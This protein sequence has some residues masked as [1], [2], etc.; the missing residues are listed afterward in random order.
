MGFQIA[1]EPT[2][3]FYVFADASAHTSDAKAFCTELILETG[4][5]ITPGI[6]FSRSLPNTWI[7][8]A[9]TQPLP[10]LDEA[11]QRIARFICG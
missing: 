10:R 7:R 5:A 8:I 9:Y 6:D 11:L 2:G 3:A 1:V 4:V